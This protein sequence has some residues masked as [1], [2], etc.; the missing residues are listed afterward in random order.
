MVKIFN[1][2]GV[3]ITIGRLGLFLKGS[4][5]WLQWAKDDHT[6]ERLIEEQLLFDEIMA[7]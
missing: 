5:G 3:L 6:R 2:I 4:V 1:V 7:H